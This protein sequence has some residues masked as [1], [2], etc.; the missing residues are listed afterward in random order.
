MQQETATA[1]MAGGFALTGGLGGVLLAAFLNRGAESRRLGVEDARRWLTDRRVAY[2]RFLT[3]CTSMHNEIDGS[4]IFLPS[5]GREV[6]PE[7]DELRVE[8]LHDYFERWDTDLRAALGDVQLLASSVVVDLAD[9]VSAALIE[10]T[11]PVELRWDFDEYYPAWVQ[12]GD[13]IDVLR[14]AM[15][16]ELGLDDLPSREQTRA[17]SEADYPWLPE[18]PSRESYV[19]GH[20]HLTGSD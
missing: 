9:R 5:H 17:R 3:V 8:R 18:R 2:A 7:E 1:L 6:S 10:I 14:N 16:A 13:L 11:S 19:Q 20:P 12:A 15:R 4:A